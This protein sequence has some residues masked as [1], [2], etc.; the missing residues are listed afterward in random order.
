[1]LLLSLGWGDFNIY[2]QGHTHIVTTQKTNTDISTAVRTSNLE[3]DTLIIVAQ[4]FL[5]YFPEIEI[6]L[7][8]SPA[9]VSCVCVYVYMYVCQCAPPS[10]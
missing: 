6:S 5:A 7:I 4:L 3:Q 1:M 10:P 2:L 8:R 9:C